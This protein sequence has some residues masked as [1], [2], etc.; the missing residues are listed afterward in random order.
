MPCQLTHHPIQWM[1]LQGYEG[2]LKVWVYSWLPTTSYRYSIQQCKQGRLQPK[3]YMNPFLYL[4]QDN[5]M[6]G[7]DKWP[8]CRRQVA[9]LIHTAQ[10]L[11]LDLNVECLMSKVFTRIPKVP[12]SGL[13]CMTSERRSPPL[14]RYLSWPLRL[15]SVRRRR[16]SEGSAHDRQSLW[17]SLSSWMIPSL[18]SSLHRVCFEAPAALDGRVTIGGIISRQ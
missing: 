11:L 1:Y 18:S 6:I 10:V 15:V 3:F 7:A 17:S 5:I 16:L 8:C 4:H 2:P 12:R 9:H 13:A 14:V